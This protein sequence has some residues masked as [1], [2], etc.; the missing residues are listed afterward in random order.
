MANRYMKR[1]STSLIIR[2]MH[3]KITMR[4]YLTPFRMAIIK[5]TFKKKR[6]YIT[7]VGEDV[8][9]RTIIHNGWECKIFQYI[10]M[11]YIKTTLENIWQFMWKIKHT[12]SI[13]PNNF[14]P[15]YLP[16]K[17]ANTCPQRDFM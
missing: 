11:R 14:T 6:Q 17:N 5:K 3:M 2:K 8:E 1:C 12:F 7:S 9:V 10:P 13:Q 16:K 15:R 4:Y